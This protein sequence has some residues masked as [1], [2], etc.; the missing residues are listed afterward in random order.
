M[1]VGGRASHAL[2]AALRGHRAWTDLLGHTNMNTWTEQSCTSLYVGF[3]F[4]PG[5]GPAQAGWPHQLLA[6]PG[7]LQGRSGR[8]ERPAGHALHAVAASWR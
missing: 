2:L 7:T 3:S 5:G 8:T 6:H 1:F 4:L